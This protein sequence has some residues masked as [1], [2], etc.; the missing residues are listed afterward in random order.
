MSNSIPGGVTIPGDNTT[1]SVTAPTLSGTIPASRM[2]PAFEA[3]IEEIEAIPDQ[4]AMKMFTDIGAVTIRVLAFL[5]SI[6]TLRSELIQLRGFEVQK[7]D[8]LERYTLAAAQAHANFT[9]T[10][11][12]STSMQELDAELTKVRTS[13]ISMAIALEN[14]GLMDATTVK[15]LRNPNGFQNLAF[16]VTSLVGLFRKNWEAIASKS[17]ITEASLIEAEDLALRMMVAIGVKGRAPETI[18]AASLTRRKALTLFVRAYDEVRRGVTFLR[19]YQDDVE[20]FTPSL[21]PNKSRRTE[22]KEEELAPELP[23]VAAVPAGS[24]QPV[25]NAGTI[26]LPSD[27]PVGRG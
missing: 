23:V 26:G 8:D 3:T 5:P 13:L 25:V 16:D 2:R 12:P 19:W 11:A 27:E 14:Y 9:I 24:T 15:N 21:A 20:S 22:T 4:A 1:P 6:A 7:L 18:S 10:S 17:P